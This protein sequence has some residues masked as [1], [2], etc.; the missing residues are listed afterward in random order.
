MWLLC[1]LEGFLRPV[2]GGGFGSTVLA[3]AAAGMPRPLGRSQS[4]DLARKRETWDPG[5]L[6][7]ASGCVCA[8]AWGG[9][10]R[11]GGWVEEAG[12]GEGQGRSSRFSWGTRAPSATPRLFWAQVDN[13]RRKEASA[14]LER[15]EAKLQG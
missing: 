9:L 8:P 7:H 14:H 12:P 1:R 2:S 4:N 6:R 5:W 3:E 11:D 10:Q 13:D 15:E